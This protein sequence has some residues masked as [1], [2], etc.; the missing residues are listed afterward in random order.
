MLFGTSAADFVLKLHSPNT[1]AREWTIQHVFN[2]RFLD[3]RGLTQL[4]T[5]LNFGDFKESTFSQQIDPLMRSKLGLEIDSVVSR[6]KDQYRI[7]FSDNTAFFCQIDS[8]KEFPQFT[9]VEYP[10]KVLTA[11][12]TESSE[13]LEE[14]FFGSEDG[15]IYQMDAGTSFDGVEMEYQLRL[16]YNNLRSPRTRKRFFNAILEI[17]APAGITLQ[18]A[19]DFTYG[20]EET[21]KGV[22]QSFDVSSGG[23]FWDDGIEW[24]DFFW[25]GQSQGEAKA[26]FKG[27]GLNMS[28]L[29]IGASTYEE[30]HTITGITVQYTLRGVRR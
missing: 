6:E 3:D 7:F 29:I 28:L 13:G 15:F 20:S 4:R 23:G 19:P 14:I 11:N 21:P 8:K 30:S 26:Y 25:G 24:S 27:S 22:V 16:P 9:R 10:L 17:D 12:T 18:F 2:T 1:G 5:T